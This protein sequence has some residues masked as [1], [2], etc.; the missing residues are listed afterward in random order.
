MHVLVFVKQ[1]PDINRIEF[2]AT[3]MR[4]KR[5]GVPLHY[6]HPIF[7]LSRSA[8][9]DLRPGWLKGWPCTNLNTTVEI[10]SPGNRTEVFTFDQ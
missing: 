4:V 2:D 9:K 6:A 8:L 1:I 5:E 3:T 7:G 10:S